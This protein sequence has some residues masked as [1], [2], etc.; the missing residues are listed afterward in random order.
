MT[1]LPTFDFSA[2]QTAVAE[3]QEKAQSAYKAAYDKS[4]TAAAEAQEFSTGNVA[5]LSEAGK[6]FTTG[7]ETIVGDFVA[8]SKAAFEAL[9]ADAKAL[10]AVKTPAELF[11]LQ[12]DLAKKHFDKAMAYGSKQS[13]VVLKLAGAVAAPLSNRVSLAVEKVKTAA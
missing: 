6:L 4:A 2:F 1:A 12:G 7:F 10:A 13:E 5:A 9:G 8:E 11:S 3:M